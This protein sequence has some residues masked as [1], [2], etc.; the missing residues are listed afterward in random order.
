MDALLEPAMRST[1]Q[2]GLDFSA[3]R[4]GTC[5]FVP[6]SI[7]HRGRKSTTLKLQS[8]DIEDG[9]L[10]LLNALSGSYK[11]SRGNARPVKGDIA[12]LAYVP[13]LRS[14]ARKLLQNYAKFK[15]HVN[16]L[17]RYPRSS[18]TDAA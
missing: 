9:A 12:K 5:C 8:Q 18:Q 7:F 2:P 3:L 16:R 10:Q 17:A 1:S 6:K 4:Y 11:D 14:G 13:G 15:A